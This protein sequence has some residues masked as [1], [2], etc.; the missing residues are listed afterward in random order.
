MAAIALAL[1][2]APMGADLDFENVAIGGA[3]D[4]LKRFAASGTAL[5]VL[6]QNA[7]LGRGRQVIVA[8]SSVPLAAWLLS[9]RTFL[10]VAI[11][12]RGR[13]LGLRLG[14]GGSFR[15]SSVE[16]TL[17]F[18]DFRLEALNLFLQVSFTQG[19][20]LDGSLMLGSVIVGL[21]T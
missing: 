21:E 2:A 4:F 7:V 14:R 13:R 6:G 20:T 5:L 19:G 10:A 16:T 1:I 17:Q 12:A 9:A 11:I 3:G 15:F 8:A 18:A